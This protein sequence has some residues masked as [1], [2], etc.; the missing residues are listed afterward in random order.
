M[1]KAFSTGLPIKAAD[2]GLIRRPVMMMTTTKNAIIRIKYLRGSVMPVSPKPLTRKVN[3]S[4]HN[5]IKQVMIKQW[6][7]YGAVKRPN[8][9]T[10]M[11]LVNDRLLA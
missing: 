11:T 6:Q 1:I 2:S 7:D 5:L 9:M 4:P 10:A 3:A 8:H